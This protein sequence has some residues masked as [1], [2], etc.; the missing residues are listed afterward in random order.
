MAKKKRK[1]FC[2]VSCGRDCKATDPAKALCF[3]CSVPGKVQVAEGGQRP[4][5][6]VPIHEINEDDY[7]E[8][9]EC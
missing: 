2:C 5:F 8:E 3:L 9:S 7:S 6:P 4:C 1:T